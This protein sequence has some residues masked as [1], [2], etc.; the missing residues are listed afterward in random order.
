MPAPRNRTMTLT[1]AEKKR[2]ASQLV[3]LHAPVSREAILDATIAQDIAGA[4]DFLPPAFVDLLFLDPPYNMKKT[5]NAAS[6]ANRSIEDYAA[7]MDA[8]LSKLIRCLNSSLSAA[9]I[10]ASNASKSFL[11]K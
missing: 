7:W 8:W 11:Y 2:Y 5:F 6:F 3:R 4:A 9:R 10:V 1:P